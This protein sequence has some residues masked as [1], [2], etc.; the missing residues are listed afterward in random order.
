MAMSAEYRSKFLPV[1]V[2]MV[3]SPYEW[4]ILEW[5]EKPQTNRKKY[6]ISNLKQNN[7]LTD[8]FILRR[9]NLQP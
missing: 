8:Q 4:K 2:V 9:K 7:A 3:T 5:D 6:T 1:M